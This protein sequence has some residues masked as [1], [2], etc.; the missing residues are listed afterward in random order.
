MA[1]WIVDRRIY[2]DWMYAPFIWGDERGQQWIHFHMP[3]DEDHPGGVREVQMLCTV[4]EAKEWLRIDTDEMELNIKV[5]IAGVSEMVM[6]YLKR[7][8]N[9][10]DD[11]IPPEV[12]LATLA[13]VGYVIRDPDGVEAA[14]LE[15]GYLP[16]HVMNILYPRRTPT[17]A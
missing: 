13:G 16:K 7:R 1:W 4:D 14:Q 2:L 10:G 5:A 3:P 17:L 9:F 8:R 6:T 12:K 15:M 11:A